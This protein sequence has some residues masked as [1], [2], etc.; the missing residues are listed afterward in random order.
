[1]VKIDDYVNF[2]SGYFLNKHFKTSLNS[3]CDMKRI[4]KAGTMFVR[5]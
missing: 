5:T 4:T 2:L 1:M 3:F